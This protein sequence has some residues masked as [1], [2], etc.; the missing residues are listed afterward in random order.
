VPDITRLILRDHARLRDLFADLDD[1]QASGST[2]AMD[3]A[4]RPLA[5]LLD[6][7]AEAEER[8]FY[9]ALLGRGRHAEDEARDAIDDH[10]E[11]RDAIRSARDAK[12]GS[13]AWWHA[14]G[15]A[16]T[17]NSKHIAE[18]ER[19]AL[20]DFRRSVG[21]AERAE[22]GLAWIE[23]VASTQP[24]PRLVVVDKDADRYIDEHT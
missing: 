8:V 24:S 2:S 20:S 10:N 17:E 7:H 6:V 4:W 12:V 13:E 16:R 15:T 21:A 14:V 22:L 1:A 23:F 18:E 5:D 19:E 11:I 9:P 3:A